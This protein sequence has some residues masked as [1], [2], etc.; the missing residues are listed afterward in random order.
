MWLMIIRSGATPLFLENV[1]DPKS[2]LAPDIQVNAHGR[3]G[4][5]TRPSRGSQNLLLVHGNIADPPVV[6]T[7]LRDA[8]RA[9][10]PDQTRTDTGVGDTDANIVDKHLRQLLDLHRRDPVRMGRLYIDT[11][12]LNDIEACCTS[13]PPDGG[14]IP[15]NTDHRTV[16]ERLAAS[17]LELRQLLDRKGLVTQ[18]RVV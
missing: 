17:A 10:L 3:A 18:P 6:A 11:G 15:P 8:T 1:D 12:S 7:R 13:H 4:F 9:D 2:S 14:R 5:N 16:N